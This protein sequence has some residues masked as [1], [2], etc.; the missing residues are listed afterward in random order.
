MVWDV[1]A[2]LASLDGAAVAS[3]RMVANRQGSAQNG[4]SAQFARL[5]ES[6][7][8]GGDSA[9]A[10]EQRAGSALAGE[11]SCELSWPT[12]HEV[13]KIA[14]RDWLDYN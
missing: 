6:T 5:M 1:A 8:S 2:K 14:R 9:Q 7:N 13:L 12:G 10:R 4:S 3:P 11:P